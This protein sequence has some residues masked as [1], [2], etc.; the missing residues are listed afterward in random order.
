MSKSL[1]SFRQI[2]CFEDVLVENVASRARERKQLRKYRQL[3]ADRRTTADST[4][5]GET[6]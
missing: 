6:T 4:K 5:Q 3:G 1:G 2:A